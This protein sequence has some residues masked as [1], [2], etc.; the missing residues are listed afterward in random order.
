MAP[1]KPRATLDAAG[2][3]VGD[4]QNTAAG[5]DIHQNDP[6]PWLEFMRGY[7][8]E[9]DQ[10]RNQRDEALAHEIAEGRKV[11]AA[12]SREFDYYQ[13]FVSDRLAADAARRTTDRLLAV[14]ALL[15]AVLALGI[16]LL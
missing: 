4:Q 9:L 8:L 6:G 12:L 7:L 2:Q 15:V 1:R 11:L 16:A 10:G 3:Q 14:A 5:G 13:R